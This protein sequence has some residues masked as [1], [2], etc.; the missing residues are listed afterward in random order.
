[1]VI[2]SYGILGLSLKPNKLET[3]F[4]IHVDENVRSQINNY[5]DTHEFKIVFKTVDDIYKK[6]HVQQGE[7]NLPALF[8]LGGVFDAQ[9]RQ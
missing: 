2:P 5:F 8:A 9:N 1:M 4:L 7:N 3:L 6:Y